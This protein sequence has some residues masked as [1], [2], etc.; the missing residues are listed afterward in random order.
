M[1]Y[2]GLECE[3]HGMRIYKTMRKRDAAVITYQCRVQLFRTTAR[4]LHKN[5]QELPNS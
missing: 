2:Y 3:C 1:T 4:E 5:Q